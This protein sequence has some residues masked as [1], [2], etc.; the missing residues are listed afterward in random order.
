[1]TVLIGGRLPPSHIGTVCAAVTATSVD[2]SKKLHV[3]SHDSALLKAIVTSSTIKLNGMS[4]RYFRDQRVRGSWGRILKK[5]R[6][7]FENAMK[8]EKRAKS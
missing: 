8:T 4:D 3:V 7:V 5:F 1:M 6:N 2:V